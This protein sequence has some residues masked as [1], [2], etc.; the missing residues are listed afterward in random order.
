MQS[1]LST[2]ILR[3]GHPLLRIPSKSLSKS[4]LSSP[5]TLDCLQLL[6]KNLSNDIIGLSA[7]QVGYSLRILGYHIPAKVLKEYNLNQAIPATFLINPT[8]TPIGS[9]TS[10][11]YESCAS[12]PTFNALVKRYDRIKIES[13]DAYGS[14][15]NFEASG[16]LSRIIQHEVIFR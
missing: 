14:P 9:K 3:A 5:E 1:F 2:K 11:N 15:L 16:I 8:Y 13:W 6:R 4:D 12:V 7:P 10:I